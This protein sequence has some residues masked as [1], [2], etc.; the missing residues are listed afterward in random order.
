V[1]AAA[2]L[3]LHRSH[4][5]VLVRIAS[6][7]SPTACRLNGPDVQHITQRAAQQVVA[8]SSDGFCSE[9]QQPGS[10]ASEIATVPAAVDAGGPT[11]GGGPGGGRGPG[12]AGS[13]APCCCI[14]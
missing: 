14:E 4:V 6:M 13:R 9:S 7:L 5:T 3:G 12:G 2:A 8:M 1:A 10:R 11:V